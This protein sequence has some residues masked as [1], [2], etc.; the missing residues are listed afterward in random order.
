MVQ[1]RGVGPASMAKSLLAHHPVARV[2]DSV[3]NEVVVD[4]GKVRTAYGRTPNWM[5]AGLALQHGHS[6]K[7]KLK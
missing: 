7:Q 3:E 6:A 4:E 1:A 2:I 5:P